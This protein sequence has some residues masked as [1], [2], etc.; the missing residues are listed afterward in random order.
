VE[1]FAEGGAS[2][3]CATNIYHFTESSIQSAKR[4]LAGNGIP[5]RM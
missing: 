4:H 5:V 2:G 1:G 3:V